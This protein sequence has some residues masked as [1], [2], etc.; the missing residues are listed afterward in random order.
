[1]T[2]FFIMRRG[3]SLAK[4]SMRAR[5]RIERS[6]SESFFCVVIAFLSAPHPAFGHPLPASRG[7]GLSI[8][9]L[10]YRPLCGVQRSRL[11]PCQRRLHLRHDRQGDLLGGFRAEV[12]ADRV[13]E[14]SAL[15]AG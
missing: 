4:E 14:P 12:E 15:E 10:V 1:M 8:S 7:E 13:V 5:R 9:L 11:P 2:G 3:S 6:N